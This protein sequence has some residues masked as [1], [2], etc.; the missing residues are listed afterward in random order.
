MRRSGPQ[1]GIS[2]GTKARTTRE[3]PRPPAAAELGGAAKR[4]RKQLP[5]ADWVL[6][7]VGTTAQAEATPAEEE[8]GQD[9][10]KK[11]LKHI[12]LQ[13]TQSKDRTPK[14]DVSLQTRDTAEL[15]LE[16][17][18]LPP[19]LSTCIAHGPSSDAG[20]ALKRDGHFC[21]CGAP[22]ESSNGREGAEGA[23]FSRASFPATGDP[24]VVRALRV[25]TSG[26]SHAA[27]H[28]PS[29]LLR[30]KAFPAVA[31]S[32]RATTATIGSNGK[33][34][35][36]PELFQEAVEREETQEADSVAGAPSRS[37]A[38]GLLEPPSTSSPYKS[39]Y[40]V[41]ASTGPPLS[42]CEQRVAGLPLSG[43]AP[44]LV[45]LG[46]SSG[47]GKSTLL[48]LLLHLLSLTYPSLSA[49]RLWHQGGGG[50]RSQEGPRPYTLIST[51]ALRQVLRVLNSTPKG[52]RT[53]AVA[54]DVS[55]R[56]LVRKL[57][58]SSTYRLKGL[59]EQQM[60]GG[61][62]LAA[63]EGKDSEAADVKELTGPSGEI[64]HRCS[65]W[66]ALMRAVEED[67]REEL[68]ALRGF[69]N[70]VPC[71][72]CGERAP[73][74]ALLGMLQQAILLQRLIL[75]PL[76]TSLMDSSCDV[77][78]PP[79]MGKPFPGPSEVGE[80][81]QALQLLFLC[82]AAAS[83]LG[84][85]SSTEK[86][87]SNHKNSTK[88]SRSSNGC[89]DFP[90]RNA[91]SFFLSEASDATAGP[92]EVLVQ[93]ANW[94]S[95]LRKAVLEAPGRGLAS[96]WEAPRAYPIATDDMLNSL[97]LVQQV[98]VKQWGTPKGGL[99]LSTTAAPAP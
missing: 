94:L 68:S 82:A 16:Y 76:V 91:A 70:P 75:E 72:S 84:S 32:G 61:G 26:V 69:P 59:A 56:S 74:C 37:A 40:R 33:S 79:Y 73:C 71:Q 95:L 50:E 83:T 85:N 54:V 43:A 81:P 88:V 24:R 9:V 42:F 89:T 46:G 41:S 6:G 99:G 14:V 13:L 49:L 34:G 63:T 58:F 64:E 55:E 17:P 35:G 62:A 77:Q 67:M 10:F 7:S 93:K 86:S 4:S 3:T 29:V 51:D 31:K 44:L 66:E 60:Q 11:H 20:R 92:A 1:M 28:F 80:S 5:A 18:T 78:E 15:F 90:G 97:Y 65:E 23:F 57:L 96:S 19:V 25:A 22:L 2:R 45:L 87:T 48:P 12:I 27:R 21:H 47:S 8:A 98:A 39:S 36:K 53:P 30:S 52:A 38:E